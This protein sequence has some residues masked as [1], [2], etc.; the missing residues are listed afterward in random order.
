MV[1]LLPWAMTSI[2]PRAR[3]VEVPAFGLTSREPPPA[4]TVTLPKLW[5]VVLAPVFPVKARVPPLRVRVLVSATRLVE[6]AMF[7]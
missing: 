3:V 1:R 4:L 7:A 2:V 5:V 6:S